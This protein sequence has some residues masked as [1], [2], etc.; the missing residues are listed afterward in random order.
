MTFENVS[1]S[2]V[3]KEI[4]EIAINWYRDENGIDM[5]QNEGVSVGQLISSAAVIFF[6]SIYPIVIS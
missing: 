5:Y 2:D 6:A 1:E 3:Y 4:S